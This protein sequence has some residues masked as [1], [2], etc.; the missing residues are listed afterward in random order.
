MKTHFSLTNHVPKFI[1]AANGLI[2]A[3]LVW[4]HL[5]IYSVWKQVKMALTWSTQII[6][7][8]SKTQHYDR[9]MK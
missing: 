1:T 7:D 9:F 5:W 8:V 6:N 4:A 3:H 2:M